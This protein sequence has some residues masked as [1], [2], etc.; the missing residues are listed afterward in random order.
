MRRIAVLMSAAA[1]VLSCAVV[2]AQ[3]PSFSGKWTLVPDP[4]AQGGRG[5]FGG[6][7]GMEAT[8]AQDAK[9]LTV[10]RAG[11]QG[12]AEIKTVYNLDG[13]E[14]KNTLSFGGNSIDQLSKVKAD[15]AKLVITTK[16]DF[17]G[18]A[19]ETTMTWSLDATGNLVVE[20][21]AP[22]FQGGG[23]PTTTKRTYKKN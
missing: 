8:V 10:T 2:L 9:T 23:A 18:N 13:S 12:G 17:G 16:S 4:N 6:G 15:G 22:D 1:V 11:I 19:F 7:L 14:T 20:S 5:G 3:T 21:V